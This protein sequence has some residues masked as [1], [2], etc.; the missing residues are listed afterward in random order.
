MPHGL[1]LYYTLRKSEEK[2][3]IL[4]IALVNRV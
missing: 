1:F 4:P 2:T 3:K